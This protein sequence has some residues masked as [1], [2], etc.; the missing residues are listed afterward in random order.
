MMAF[1]WLMG[2]VERIALIDS[3]CVVGVGSDGGDAASRAGGAPYL[4]RA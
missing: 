1:G 4:Q 3:G 2:E